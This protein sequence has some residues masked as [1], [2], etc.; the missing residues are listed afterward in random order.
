MKH[1]DK[2]GNAS[3]FFYI[4]IVK[5]K[6]GYQIGLGRNLPLGEAGMIDLIISTLDWQEE[7]GPCVI[8]VD[9]PFYRFLVRTKIEDIYQD[10]IPLPED[11]DVDVAMQYVR[12]FFPIEIFPVEM[13]NFQ[14]L[15]RE[16]VNYYMKAIPE[17][18]RT[19]WPDL[20]NNEELILSLTQINSN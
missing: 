18:I 3:F 15:S 17:D 20:L 7:N 10:I 2:G 19:R 9:E 12:Q 16:D 1:L 5:E 4:C 13:N 11:A 6:I 14:K 8:F